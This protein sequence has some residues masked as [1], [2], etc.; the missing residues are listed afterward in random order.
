MVGVQTTNDDCIIVMRQ[1]QFTMRF[2]TVVDWFPECSEHLCTDI[3]SR[4]VSHGLAGCSGKLQ[5]GVIA[6]GR[7]STPG[8]TQFE[9][10]NQS[11]SIGDRAVVETTSAQLCYDV[12]DVTPSVGEITVS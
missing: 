9:H 4:A 2:S 1:L 3:G 5:P 6:A 11:Q 12:S 8:C 10:A 7:S